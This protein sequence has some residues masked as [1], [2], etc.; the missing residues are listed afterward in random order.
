[1]SDPW[2]R[3]AVLVLAPY[4]ALPDGADAVLDNV[5]EFEQQAVDFDAYLRWEA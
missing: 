5:V 1:M 4:K 2:R 3:S